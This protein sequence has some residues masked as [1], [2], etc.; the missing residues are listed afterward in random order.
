MRSAIHALK[1]LPV[2]LLLLSGAPAVGAPTVCAADGAEAAA[3]APAGRP[4]VQAPRPAGDVF[5]G[6]DAN[7]DGVVT[8]EEFQAAFPNM[9]EAAFNRIDANQ[10]AV[11][12]RQEWDAFRASHGKGG[13]SPQ[14]PPKMPPQTPQMPPPA[15]EGAKPGILPPSAK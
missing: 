15:R 12:D 8:R 9:R 5:A 7:H 14:M 13:M 4:P 3:P 10:D 1:A 11:I 6:L 2:A